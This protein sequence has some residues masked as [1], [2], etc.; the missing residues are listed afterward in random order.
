MATHE[1]KKH[2]RQYH[3][4]Q[5]ASIDEKLRAFKQP[6]ADIDLKIEELRIQRNVLTDQMKP[7]WDEQRQYE[8]MGDA[9][10]RGEIYSENQYNLIFNNNLNRYRLK[11][12][13]DDT[14]TV[15]GC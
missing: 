9:I 13:Y 7:I 14:H 4:K 10:M 2:M 5:L 3:W 8:V 15:R 11:K 12:A 6:L 1:E